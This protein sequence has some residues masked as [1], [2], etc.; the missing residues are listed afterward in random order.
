MKNILVD[1][2][3]NPEG[4]KRLKSIKDVTVQTITA[5]EDFRHIEPDIIKD[6]HILFCTYPPTN[7]ADMQK[8]EFVQIASAGYTQ[9]FG[10]GLAERNIKAANAAGVNDITIAQWNI[11]MMINLAR[12]MRGMIRNQEAGIWDRPARFQMDIRGKT[13]GIWGYGGIGRETARLARAIGMNVH[14]FDVRVG[15]R[16]N[17]FAVDGTGDKAGILP[18]RVFSTDQKKE[19]LNGLDFLVLSMPLTKRTEGII[20]YE[21]L[22]MLPAHA[23]VLNPARGPLIKEQALLQVLREGKI[24][25]AALDTHY[26][27][28]MPAD[29]PLWR[30]PN[31]I[32]TPHISGS[33]LSPN[34]LP[35]LWDL[36]VQ[37][38]ERYISGKPLL[39][40]LSPEQLKG[41]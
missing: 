26:Y 18:N 23:F 8:L 5:V 12:D 24:S 4:L 30:F 19:F 13:V 28:P 34:F 2:D 22:T 3:I 7:L 21:E 15:P 9:L 25:G 14:A 16:E 32:M 37:N 31:V 39:N 17:M 10:L 11:A 20:G 27:Y 29:H 40:E 41:L 38:V 33:T 6:K 1:V 35:L 36:F